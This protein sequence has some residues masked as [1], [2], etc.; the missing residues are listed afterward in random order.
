MN[1]TSVIATANLA[2][3]GA[4]WDAVGTGDYNG[5]GKADIL[6]Q[7]VITGTPLIWTMNGTSV[8]ASATLPN[9]GVLWHANTG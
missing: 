3:P 8:T 1:G 5:D 4:A 2:N 9:P 6:F 7:N